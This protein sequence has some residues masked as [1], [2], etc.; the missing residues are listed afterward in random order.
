MFIIKIVLIF[1]LLKNNKTTAQLI[2]KIIEIGEENCR[3]TKISKYSNGDMIVSTY[4]NQRFSFFYHFYGL[5]ENGRPL[6][7]KDGKETPF[8][9]INFEAQSFLYNMY[10][11]GE[12]GIIKTSTTK[13]EYLISFGRLSTYTQLYDFENQNI[14]Y[15]QTMNLFNLNLIYNIRGSLFSLKDTNNYL[16]A[17][18]VI[19]NNI[20]WPYPFPST[21][22]K[23]L[24]L[25]SLCFNKKDSISTE[26]IILSS[27]SQLQA[28]GNM[29]SCFQTDGK[30]IFCFYIF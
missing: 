8:N 12:A 7:I 11:D 25:Y 9:Y 29:V 19:S 21:S 16:Y 13:E 2:D 14:I 4:A 10:N 3:F 20:N 28:Y 22:N 1:F 6:F 24:T 18:I 5:K 17:G 23:Y 30:N 27:S 26:T 15:K